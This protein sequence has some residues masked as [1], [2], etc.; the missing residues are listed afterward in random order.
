MTVAQTDGVT[1]EA[2]PAPVKKAEPVKT[3]E[4]FEEDEEIEEPKK[5]APKKAAP[6][7][8]LKLDALVDAWD[9]D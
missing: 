1:K 5:V 8:D 6:A 2:E 7:G 3:P 4:V 9:D